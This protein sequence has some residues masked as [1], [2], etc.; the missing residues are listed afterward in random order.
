MAALTRRAPHPLED[1]EGFLAHSIALS[2]VI[3]S[4]GYPFDEAAQRAQALA[5][6]KRAYNPAGFGRQIAAMVAAGDLRVRLKTIAVPT[7]VM[8]GAN[9]VLMPPAGGR[10]TAANINGAKL[11]I[12][13]GMGHDLPPELYEDVISAIAENARRA[14]QLA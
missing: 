2:R 5:E 6:V 8:H 1:E 7:L 10:D 13:E 11:R 9:D 4:P 3:G 14:R 12:I